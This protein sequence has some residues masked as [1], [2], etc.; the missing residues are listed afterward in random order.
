MNTNQIRNKLNEI[1]GNLEDKLR[2][3]KDIELAVEN[4]NYINEENVDSPNKSK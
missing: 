3:S 4:N 2:P 1:E